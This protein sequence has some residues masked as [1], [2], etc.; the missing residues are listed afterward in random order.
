MRTL[1]ISPDQL[2]NA[3][4]ATALRRYPEIELI[5]PIT[6]YPEPDELMRI[7]RARRPDFLFIGVNDIP[8]FKALA[9][10]VG[11]GLAG[12]PVIALGRDENPL[13]LVPQLMRLGVRE[14]LTSPITQE[15]LKET[16]AY[17]AA[18]LSKHPAPVLRL[19]ELNAFLPAKPG[20]G[21]STIAM[22]TSCALAHELGV[23]TI[24][25]DCDLAAGV[26][27]FLLKLGSSA[28]IV[29]AMDQAA[30]LD[31]D[32]WS[33]MVGK[34]DGLD[35]LHA[36]EL[37]PPTS[38]TASGLDKVLSLAR[39]QY[40]TICADLASSMDP[41]SVQ[42]MREARRILLVT[43]PEL[44]P[45]HMAADRL[46]HLN[47]L[48]LADKV[49]L[50]LNRKNPVRWGLP[51]EQVAALVGL[52]IAHR[53]SNDYPLVQSAIL[54]GTP[55][56]NRS[57]LGQS[58]MGLARSLAPDTTRRETGSVHHRKFLEFFHIPSSRDHET[59]WH[60]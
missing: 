16:I 18:Q 1:L 9:A 17:T 21:S 31:E 37:D 7:I 19:G 49:S 27:K 58:I 12:L 26:T 6:S 39:A 8:R 40:E 34:F 35:I 33:Q 41:F 13:E 54:D 44:V 14:L 2:L 42:I 29:N 51:D 32:L 15:K 46:R 57:S 25:L 59:V 24:L 48:G 22:S 52:P 47:E 36:G 45:L 56:S 28:S 4:L 50:L 60:D 53:F 5:H 55:V 10:A 38:L 11:E 20:V 30:S 43:T 3:E 23:R